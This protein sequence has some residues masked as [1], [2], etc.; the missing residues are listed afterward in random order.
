MSKNLS[1]KYS[2]LRIFW[3]NSNEILKLKKDKKNKD[4]NLIIYAWLSLIMNFI[5]NV[6][7]DEQNSKMVMLEGKVDI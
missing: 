7:H 1:F 4:R 3:S 5:L 2:V 6:Y